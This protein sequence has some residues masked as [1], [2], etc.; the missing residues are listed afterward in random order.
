MGGDW[1]E[2]ANEANK[3]V[4]KASRGRLLL[5]AV[6]FF[7]VIC[8]IYGKVAVSCGFWQKSLPHKSAKTSKMKIFVFQTASFHTC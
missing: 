2:A 5:I 4:A 1:A 8:V 6:C 7:A 3:K